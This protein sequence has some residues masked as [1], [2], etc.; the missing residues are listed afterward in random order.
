MES[1]VKFAIM[2]IASDKFRKGESV[3]VEPWSGNLW[4]VSKDFRYEVVHGSSIL[5]MAQ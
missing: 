2:K 3:R 1:A 4:R 5:V